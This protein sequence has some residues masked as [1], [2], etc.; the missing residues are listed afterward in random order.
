ML[1]GCGTPACAATLDDVPA[2][3]RIGFGAVGVRGACIMSEAELQ[4]R[5]QASGHDP[6]RWSVRSA[7][8]SRVGAMPRSGN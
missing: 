3:Q 7:D 4:V 6:G 8:A 2:S 5:G 1:V